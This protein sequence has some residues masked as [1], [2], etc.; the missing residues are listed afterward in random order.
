MDKKTATLILTEQ[1]RKHN[2]PQ[3]VVNPQYWGE[4][5]KKSSACY[6]LGDVVKFWSSEIR[7]DIRYGHEKLL[8]KTDPKA[9]YFF[10][11]NMELDKYSIGSSFAVIGEEE[12][13]A[14]KN[15]LYKDVPH[16]AEIA[17]KSLNIRNYVE[18]YKNYFD[19]GL[20]DPLGK[21]STYFKFQNV[22]HNLFYN[23]PRCLTNLFENY[24]NMTIKDINKKLKDLEITA[25][26]SDYEHA[27]N[28]DSI[29]WI[30]SVFEQS[31]MIG[32]FKD[33]LPD[34]FNLVFTIPYKE[35]NI[36]ANKAILKLPCETLDST[37]ILVDE[38]F[39]GRNFQEYFDC[40]GSE[41]QKK[42][43]SVLE[44]KKANNPVYNSF[45]WSKGFKNIGLDHLR[46]Y[47][48]DP[49]GFINYFKD[50]KD[51]EKKAIL[52]DVMSCDVTNEKVISWLN[53][54]YWD[55]IREVG[56]SN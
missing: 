33:L 2:P 40:L 37:K 54:N 12:V 46:L 55:M 17:M 49:Q 1:L 45:L 22:L 21:C 11:D 14:L 19:G 53:Q 16:D 32:Q 44:F 30:I 6:Q 13:N 34:F 9:N 50:K 56:L 23:Q 20:D 31:T 39:N 3:I 38:Y 25:S 35:R 36:E 41:E 42:V 43:I 10:T 28:K 4:L 24:F 7:E 15:I 48:D 26:V 29:T 27:I 18:L 5:I 8:K 47:K 51:E 52:N